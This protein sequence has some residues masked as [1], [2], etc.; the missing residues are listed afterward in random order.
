MEII[1]ITSAEEYPNQDIAN[2][3]K[4][5]GE[6]SKSV[7]N[8]VPLSTFKRKYAVLEKKGLN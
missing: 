6:K 8:I 3:T 5:V 7:L 2:K 1:L 4:Q